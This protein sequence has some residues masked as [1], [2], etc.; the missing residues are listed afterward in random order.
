LQDEQRD[1]TSIDE[2]ACIQAQS[3]ADWIEGLSY[4]AGTVRLSDFHL[5]AGMEAPSS[6]VVGTRD[7]I[8]PHLVSGSI[9]D[10]MGVIATGLTVDDVAPDQLRE[11]F[12][13]INQA[14]AKTKTSASPYSWTPE[15]LEAACCEG[16]EAMIRHYD[17]PETFLDRFEDRGRAVPR[18]LETSEYRRAVPG[19]LRRMK[20]GRY[21]VGLNFGGNHF[22]EIQAVDELVDETTAREWGI[23]PGQILVMYHLGPGPLGSILSNLYAY[24]TKPQL[25]RK[26]GY[27]F[28]RNALQL[29]NGREYH[30]TFAAFK[31]W[32]VIEA[33]SEM[34]AAYENVLNVIKN[35]G[36]AYR[37]GTIKAILD[38][39]HAVAGRGDKSEHLI[40]DLSHNILQPEDIGGE[41]LWVSRHNCCRPVPGSPGIVAGNHQVPSCLTIGPPGCDDKIGG[42]DHGIGHLLNVADNRGDSRPDPR[43]LEVQRLFM[44]RGTSRLHK[45]EKLP[46]LDRRILDETMASL[47]KQGFARPVAMLRPLITLKHKV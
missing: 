44:T 31:K 21:E 43:S 27:A 36:Y 25:Y 18:R 41:R 47:E 19:Y 37:T 26:I 34:G 46:L 29:R 23:E 45:T 32:L 28:L 3:I 38:A 13:R 8:V 17:L 14:A 2:G 6:F 11:I 20:I 9:N 7:Y 33:D 5:K 1:M 22:L 10:G 16:A 30:K 42:F 35:Y 12:L 39:V 40:I 15:L 24:R 4:V